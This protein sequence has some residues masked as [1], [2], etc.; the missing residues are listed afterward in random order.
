M[1]TGHWTLMSDCDSLCC[2]VKCWGEK[3]GETKGPLVWWLAIMAAQLSLKGTL[4]PSQLRP[5]QPARRPLG[6]WLKASCVSN[7]A[8]PLKLMRGLSAYQSW[9]V[10]RARPQYEFW[11]QEHSGRNWLEWESVMTVFG[12]VC[13]CKLEFCRSHHL[14]F[15]WRWGNCSTLF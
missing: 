7:P 4:T 8:A 11:K 1:L 15:T 10:W 9:W 13:C 14:S 6:K 12:L 3:R 5:G 2:F